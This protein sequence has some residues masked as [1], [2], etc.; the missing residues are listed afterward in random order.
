VARF[1]PPSLCELPQLSTR[2]DRNAP[3]SMIRTASGHSC[4]SAW[5]SYYQ[6]P[7]ARA[8]RVRGRPS[9]EVRPISGPPA[10][11][12]VRYD[13]KILIT[14]ETI[15]AAVIGEPGKVY[16]TGPEVAV[17]FDGKTYYI[18][19]K[20]SP[21]AFSEVT[22]CRL[23][24]LAGLK[25]PAAHV[26]SFNGDL[27][28]GTETVPAPQRNIR[29]WFRDLH[30][31]NNNGDLFAV[32]AVDT[33]LVNNDRNMGNL[34]GSSLGDGRIDIFMIDFE[35]SRT[36][37]ESPFTSSSVVAPKSLWPTG[38]LGQILR[39]IRPRQCPEPGLRRIRELAAQQIATVVTAVAAELPF[40]HWHESSVELLFK[41]A[42]NIH[43]LVEAVWVH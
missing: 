33:W 18:K 3:A 31:I 19:G 21:T 41:R 2:P 40:I 29:H 7:N 30:R 27:Y 9:T 43:N 1:S 38:E 10:S 15:E 32:V 17:G 25:V 39:N 16:S 11:Q 35:K 34:V 37:G 14:L 20:N 24:A 28:A 13:A 8:P 4:H 12:D 22:G 6:G 23:A 26:C 42:Q 36:L 5:L